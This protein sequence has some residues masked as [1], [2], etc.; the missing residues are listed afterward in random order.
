MMGG[1]NS[2]ISGTLSVVDGRPFFTRLR[3]SEGFTAVGRYY[4]MDWLSVWKD[5]AGGLLIAGALAAWVPDAFWKTLF[6]EGHPTLALFWEPLLGPVVSI[7][8]FVCSV[9]NVPLAAVLWNAGI[10]FGG[11][12]SFIFADL[13]VLPLLDIYPRYYGGKMAL[14][15]LGTLYVTMAAAGLVVEFLFRAFWLGSGQ[16]A[17]N[18]RAGQRQ[19][20]R[21]FP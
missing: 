17:G 8:S 4:V 14:Y 6:W 3:S 18:R 10:S 15:L 9:G 12:V 21:G 13:I 19:L 20:E 16:P 11:V 5:V 2:G 1:W 7:I